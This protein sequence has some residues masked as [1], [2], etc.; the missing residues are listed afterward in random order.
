MM[1]HVLSDNRAADGVESVDTVGDPF[2]ISET[3]PLFGI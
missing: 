2:L 3:A 1:C